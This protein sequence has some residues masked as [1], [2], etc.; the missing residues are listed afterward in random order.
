MNPERWKKVSELFQAA[1]DKDLPE[2]DQFLLDACDD[3]AILNEVRSLLANYEDGFL[4]QT[5][6]PGG[7]PS[8]VPEETSDSGKVRMVGRSFSH[9]RILDLLGAGGMG[10]VFIAEDTKLERKVAIKVLRADLT[11]E[12]KRKRRFIQEARA[13]ASIEHPHIADVYEVDDFEGRTF[14]AMEYVRGTSLR[15]AINKGTLS[16]RQGLEISRQII[17]A[18]AKVHEHGL[19]HRDLKPE[20]ILVSEDGYAKII[21]FGL[22]KLVEPLEPKA[23]VDS[24]EETVSKSVFRSHTGDVVGT[25]SYMSPEQARGEHV[26]ARS[27]VFSFGIVLHEL[28]TGRH[29]FRGSSTLETLSNIL[30]APPAPLELDGSEVTPEIQRIISKSL[31]KKP[32]ERYQNTKDMALDLTDALQ[33]LVGSGT[34]H[35]SSLKRYIPFGLFAVLLLI[36]T[37]WL[38]F[39]SLTNPIS[40]AGEPLSLLV[41]DFD[42]RTDEPV[43]AG[44]LEQAVTT[45]LEQAPFITC[46][47]RPRARQQAGQLDPTAGGR[48]DGNLA[49][50]V[51]QKQGIELTMTG[52]IEEKDSE[53]TITITAFDSISSEAVAEASAEADSSTDVLDAARDLAGE[54]RRQLGV[55]TLESSGGS[56]ERFLFNKVPRGIESLCARARVFLARQL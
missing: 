15:E 44:A 50:L 29:P 39:R 24:Q 35:V 45:G 41:A 48:L 33:S 22:A 7:T 12:T 5:A 26:D 3:P 36:G 32:D 30:R 31:N 47:K 2:R 18:L 4:E 55:E 9:Y 10:E 54:I 6:E 38:F 34:T 43:F 52:I 28:V 21:D 25:L 20:N 51:S 27:D 1:L 11:R 17:E 42:N 19:V 53:Y 8:S 14:I 37:L 16:L 49:A 46:Y 13:A 56:T 40:R 23:D